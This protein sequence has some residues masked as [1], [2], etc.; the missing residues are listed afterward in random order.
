M[1]EQS[2][3]VRRGVV[4]PDPLVGLNSV[5]LTIN[6]K[7]FSLEDVVGRNHGVTSLFAFGGALLSISFR[8]ATGQ[9][10][11]GSAVL[12][13][14]GIA[15]TAKHVL[16]DWLA[17]LGRGGAAAVCQAPQADH[18]HVWDIVSVHS[19]DTADLAVLVLRYRTDLPPL[20]AFS[21][22]YITTRMPTVG[23]R[24]FLAGFTAETATI[25]ISSDMRIGGNVRVSVGRV[26][27]VWPEGRDRVMLPSASFAVDSP[28]FGGMS[29][30]PVLDS[31]GRMI[32]TVS[33]STEG[34]DMAFVSHVWPS[35]L[36]LIEPVWPVKAGST[37]VAPQ[38]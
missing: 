4:T 28:A 19:L 32:G 35:L 21:V 14:P 9:H 27:D 38:I 7:L 20:N 31:Q 33:S 23:D 30:G 26:I 17:A 5:S 6:A 37:E 18:V 1:A 22:A 10:T 25:P 15:I 2:K 3:E 36:A 24:V 8:D 29:G 34:D 11:L 13:H 12:V 16:S